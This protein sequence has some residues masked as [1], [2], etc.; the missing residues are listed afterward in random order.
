MPLNCISTL[1]CPN[2]TW[3]TCQ[4]PACAV[5][6]FASRRRWRHWT[7]M[8]SLSLCWF[9]SATSAASSDTR[10]QGHDICPWASSLSVPEV[11]LGRPPHSG[12]KAPPLVRTGLSYGKGRVSTTCIL[13]RFWAPVLQ[14]WLLSC[15]L[16]CGLGK[17]A[18]LSNC[19]LCTI[20]QA[21]KLPVHIAM[22][23]LPPVWT[24]TDTLHFCTFSTIT[25]TECKLIAICL[26]WDSAIFMCIHHLKYFT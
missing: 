23:F 7:A 14:Q 21:I 5:T 26:W 24:L 1:H 20:I 17:P 16:T 15:P 8:G 3:D 9:L 12:A 18:L 6:D 2:T 22:W 11:R 4:L 13:L 25:I 19:V 10:H